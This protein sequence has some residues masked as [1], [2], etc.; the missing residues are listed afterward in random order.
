MVGKHNFDGVKID[1]KPRAML[2]H[3]I[4]ISLNSIQIIPLFSKIRRLDIVVWYYN[5][6]LISH[7]W[8]EFGVRAPWGSSC[9]L[10]GNYRIAPRMKCP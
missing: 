9:R 6:D 8:D 4:P 3:V 7:H 1:Y 10:V 5:W 2:V